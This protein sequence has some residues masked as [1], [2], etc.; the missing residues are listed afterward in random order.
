MKLIRSPFRR[1]PKFFKAK[2]GKRST[3]GAT[4][5]T[6]ELEGDES[7]VFSVG[8]SA[9]GEVDDENLHTVEDANDGSAERLHLQP[10]MARLN[11]LQKQQQIQ[12]M[13]H[14]DVLFA[15]K[16]LARAHRRHEDLEKARFVDDILR[17]G[18]RSQGSSVAG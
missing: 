3:S 11:A 12:G 15:F 13:H 7:D 16:H 5:V 2:L 10:M 4:H 1:L 8:S 14:P 6:M 18:V 17:D 9:P